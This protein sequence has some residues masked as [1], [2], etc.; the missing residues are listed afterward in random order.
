MQSCTLS[1]RH[2][3]GNTNVLK[4][5]NKKYIFK[6]QSSITHFFRV[7]VFRAKKIYYFVSSFLIRAQK[8]ERK[9]YSMSHHIFMRAIWTDILKQM[10]Y[11][12][13]ECVATQF[14]NEENQPH[15]NF[16]YKAER[17]VWT[18]SG[19][20]YCFVV[21]P[22]PFCATWKPFCILE[23]K[24]ALLNC[25]ILI[26]ILSSLSSALHILFFGV[27]TVLRECIQSNVALFR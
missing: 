24:G 14:P 1:Q 20:N 25:I 21:V 19:E 6:V 9:P 15:Q 12:N 26:I 13:F 4:I 17:V 5:L 11:S 7:V 10:H 3:R 8:E 16:S 2:R 18:H 27:V 23:S 22:F